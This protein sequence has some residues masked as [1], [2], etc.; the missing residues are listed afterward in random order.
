MILSKKAL[1]RA[2]FVEK[3]RIYWYN[4]SNNVVLEVKICLEDEDVLVIHLGYLKHNTKMAL[5]SVLVFE[6]VPNTISYEISS[7]HSSEVIHGVLK[8]V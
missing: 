4:I 8:M 3:V 6:N 1:T 7:K 2:F 5:P